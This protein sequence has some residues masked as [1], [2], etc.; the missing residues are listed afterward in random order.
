MS[1][2]MHPIVITGYGGISPI[3]ESLDQTCASV[4]AG[5][6]MFQAHPIYV[7]GE[8][9]PEWGDQKPMI[10]S[11]VPTLEPDLKGMDRLEALGLAALL[12]LLDRLPLKREDI[13][14]TALFFALPRIDEV[15]RTWGL[16]DAFPKRIAQT[17]GLDGLKRIGVQ[18]AGHAG[19]FQLL[20]KTYELLTSGDVQHCILVGLDSFVDLDR[21]ALM[22]Q[23]WRLKSDRTVD[24]FIP[25]EGAAAI[26]LEL[27]EAAAR[28]ERK[29]LA[30]IVGFGEGSE[31]NQLS[32]EKNSL[33]EGLTEAIREATAERIPEW[34]LCDMNGEQYWGFEWGVVQTRLGPTLASMHELTHAADCTG[35]IGAA[36]GPMMLGIVAR[37]L[38]KGYAPSEEILCWTASE[39]EERSAV[40]LAAGSEN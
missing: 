27:P 33:G 29:E 16:D 38:A 7:A 8:D 31:P 1:A 32:H 9:N 24:G 23:D 6:D 12:D 3:G 14:D 5:I 22:D 18:T 30:R 35:E 19:G 10:A 40:Y 21:L 26:L 34:V 4:R 11:C 25:G 39:G 13:G 28:G 2:G 20:R 15:T 36:S 37:A 17:A